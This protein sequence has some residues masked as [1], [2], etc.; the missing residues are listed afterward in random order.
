MDHIAEI[1]RREGGQILASLI[2]ASGSF[3]LAEDAMQDAFIIAADTWRR[4]T[5]RRR[6][7]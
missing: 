1:F 2:R 3:E 4:D 5:R 6:A 7:G